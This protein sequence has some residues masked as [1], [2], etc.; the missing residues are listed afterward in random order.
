MFPR[1]S[2]L[3]PAARRDR[4]LPRRRRARRAARALERH[5]PRSPSASAPR[6]YPDGTSAGG[7]LLTWNSGPAAAMRR[8]P[9]VDER[10]L[11]AQ[12]DRRAGARLAGGCE[13]VYL[14]GTRNG[15]MMAYRIAPRLPSWSPA[16]ASSPRPRRRRPAARA[17]RAARR[18]PRPADKNVLWKAARAEPV[19]PESARSI[20]RRSRSGRSG[21]AAR[22]AG[23][24]RDR[25]RLRDGALRRRRPAAPAAPSSST[26]CPARP[27]LARRRA[28]RALPQPRA[29][30]ENGRRLHAHLAVLRGEVTRA[31][32]ASLLTGAVR[33]V[34]DPQHAV[35]RGSATIGSLSPRM[36]MTSLPPSTV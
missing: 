9:K 34:V 25:R 29:A 24:R 30:R 35:L 10:R 8:A 12:A 33:H 13:R 19:R 2:K 15:G 31:A 17:R 18:L 28:G 26:S 16:P 3:P 36:R 14:A 32:P 22:A 21:T 5:E 27:L 4:Q 6:R 23:A 1:R 7:P 11:R 20:P